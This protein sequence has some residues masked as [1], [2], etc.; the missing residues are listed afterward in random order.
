MSTFIILPPPHPSRQNAIQAVQ[1][2]QEGTCVVLRDVTRTERQN[3][4][5]QPLLREWATKAEPILVNGEPTRL[6]MDDWRHILVAKF[7][8]EE[9]RYALFEGT[10]IIL[11]ASSKE[12][13]TKE[14]T[15]FVEYLHSLAGQR[16]FTLSR[17]EAA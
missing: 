7:R 10:L 15:D 16:G 3:A 17:I 14:C 5:I 4:M 2:A 1:E 9:T 8:H 11:G 12:L 13:T 6:N